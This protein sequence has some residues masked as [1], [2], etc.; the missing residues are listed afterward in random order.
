[1]STGIS[2]GQSNYF[3]KK[4]GSAASDFARSVKQ[5]SDS[6]IYVG[7]YSNGG[8]SG[9]FDV[10]LSKLTPNGEHLWTKYYGDSLDEFGLFMN[11]TFDNNLIITGER[12]SENSGLD[13]FILKLDSAGNKMWESN[14]STPVN[15]SVKFIEQTSD[16]GYILCG[17]QN[18][19]FGSND[20]LVFKT[21]S[22]GQLI[23]RK[24][25]GGA[26]NDYADMIHQ[27]KEGGYILTAD[28]RSK[29]A[30]GYD[31]NVIKLNS[32]G[33][34][35]WDYTYGDDLE[36]GCQGVLITSDGKYLSYGETEVYLNSPFNFYLELLDTNGTSLWKT[37]PG[38]VNADA[39][40][41]A[42][43]AEDKGFI[44]TGYSNSYNS[45]PI[46]LVVFKTDSVGNMEW[47]Q[48]YGGT[49]IDLGY[50]IIYSLTNG[51]LVTGKTNFNNND[52]FYLLHLN[53][54]GTLI[55]ERPDLKNPGV[56]L[57]VYPNPSAGS[58]NIM[59]YKENTQLS[60]SSIE[61]KKLMEMKLLK[62]N[63][64]ITL[65]YKAGIY[66]FTFSDDLTHSVQRVIL[67]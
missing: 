18:D 5:L 51:L 30:G 55:T 16:G 29:G 60:I 62:G 33:N 61:G 11:K 63:N 46:N 64:P 35:I 39:A 66:L 22:I 27:T 67:K 20:I 14:Y 49:N 54:E 44:L 19:N 32:V 21:D 56:Q 10:S 45:G 2:F 52:E 9:S 38:G 34:I 12:Y 4:F 57:L 48:T 28:T 53:K 26:D 15:E 13:V 25:F 24:T 40:F 58:F 65:N 50:E 43:E 17:F 31:I 47:V 23:W 7:G 37:T 1:M 42:V 8:V 6:S 36:N 59:C 3:E 41:F